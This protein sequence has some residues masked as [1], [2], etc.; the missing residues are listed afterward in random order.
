[1]FDLIYKDKLP[2]NIKL[3]FID[4]HIFCLHKD[5]LDPTKLRPI[6]IPTAIRR[7]IASHVART[8]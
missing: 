4:V 2:E 7:L 8:L 3:Y 1:M 5:P 6:G